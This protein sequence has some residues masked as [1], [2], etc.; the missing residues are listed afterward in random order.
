MSCKNLILFGAGASYG[1]DSANTPPL[2]SDL[3]SELSRFNLPGWGALPGGLVKVFKAD[4]EKGMVQVAESNPHLNAGPTAC[5]GGVL[6]QLH[7]LT[8]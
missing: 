4:F 5:N 7:P 2:G 1:S 8:Q 3:F 6:L